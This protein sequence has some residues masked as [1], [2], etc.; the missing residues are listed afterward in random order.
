MG[1]I[2]KVIVEVVV[3]LVVLSAAVWVFQTRK[4]TVTQTTR[5][6][7][8]N[9]VAVVVAEARLTSDRLEAL[10]T[11]RAKE[12]VLI[13]AS[14][15][16]RVVGL[17]FEDGEVVE[18]GRLLA[19]LEERLLLAER[20]IAVA[21]LEEERREMERA[22]ELLEKEGIARRI[23]DARETS[24]AKAELALESIDARLELREV[25]APFAGVL[26]LRRVSVG[27]WVSPGTVITTLDDISEIHID[28][29]VPEQYLGVIGTGVKFE[30]RTAALPDVVVTGQVTHVEA[31]I[32]SASLSATARGTVGNG[33]GRLR[34][35]MQFAVWLETSP[36]MSVWV[37]EKAMV[38][39]GEKQFVYVEA[40]GRVSRRE[41]WL[42]RREAGMV[43]VREGLV[44]GERV[45][46]DGVGKMR[47]GMMVGVRGNG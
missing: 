36:R 24:L 47:E 12:S 28:F 6:A 23:A 40:G 30:A 11:G 9:E 42:G 5:A 15:S 38:S 37:P 39:L 7:V 34:P 8:T 26:G 3:G 31:R 10:G 44:A 19:Q 27:A 46:T 16:E 43:E 22:R 25:R 29:S 18:A 17:F 4:G 2:L 33:D 21:V 41:V 1:K 32:D 20:K 35:G 45:V 14:E 13:T